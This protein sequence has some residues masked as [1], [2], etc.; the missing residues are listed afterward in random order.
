LDLAGL[1]E[2]A[3]EGIAIAAGA[4]RHFDLILEFSFDRSFL[5]IIRDQVALGN[6]GSCGNFVFEL[7][8]GGKVARFCKFVLWVLGELELVVPELTQWCGST[9]IIGCYRVLN[10]LGRL[11]PTALPTSDLN[12]VLGNCSAIHAYVWC[13]I[14]VCTDQLSVWPSYRLYRRYNMHAMGHAPPNSLARSTRS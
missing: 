6:A 9:H 13:K 3:L 4:H 14:D 8:G 7:V 5:R 11:Q 12:V 1:L 2:A 10:F